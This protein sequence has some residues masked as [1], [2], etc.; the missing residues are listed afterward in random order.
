MSTGAD[1]GIAA[2]GDATAARWPCD[3]P[4]TTAYLG[5]SPPMISIVRTAAGASRHARVA[6][7][8][9]LRGDRRDG[10]GS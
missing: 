4:K 10:T 6:S 8:L 1:C 5:L 9:Y 7:K 3:Y 2:A